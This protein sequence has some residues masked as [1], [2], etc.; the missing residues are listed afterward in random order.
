MAEMK[1]LSN[2]RRVELL[3]YLSQLCEIPFVKRNKGIELLSHVLQNI[4]SDPTNAEYQNLNYVKVKERLVECEACFYLLLYVGFKRCTIANSERLK[5]T[6]NTHNWNAL[7]IVNNRIQTIIAADDDDFVP[8][9]PYPNCNANNSKYLM[10]PSRY[11]NVV[12]E[13][14]LSNCLCFKVIT[15]V[16]RARENERDFQH[17][18]ESIGNNYNNIELMN[19]FNHLLSHH[20]NELEMEEIYN[21]LVKQIYNN[22]SCGLAKC[23]FMRRNHRNRTLITK[24]EQILNELYHSC[25]DIVSQQLLDRIHC[26]FLHSYDIG[27]KLT[28]QQKIDITNEEIKVNNEND[29]CFDTT[30]LQMNEIRKLTQSK[31]KNI[32]CFDRL[33]NAPNKFKTEFTEQKQNVSEQYQYGFRFYYWKHSKSDHRQWIEDVSARKSFKQY[34]NLYIDQKYRNLEDE[35]TNNSVCV[36]SKLQFGQLLQKAQV[37]VDSDLI[38]EIFCPRKQSA[39]CY[40][41][42]YEQTMSVEHIISLMVY[43]NYD[44]LQR[45]FSET[46]RKLQNETNESLKNRHRNYYFFAKLL[47]ECVGCFG[48]YREQGIGNHI[49]V[50]HGIDKVL[51]FTTMDTYVAGPFSTTTDYSVATNFCAGKGMILEMFIP[52]MEWMMSAVE[53]K[54]ALHRI[55]CMDMQWFSDFV[56]E[57]EI[58]CIGGLNKIY[59]KSIILMNGINYMSYIGGLRRMI[60][61]MIATDNGK[62]VNDAMATFVASSVHTQ[63]AFRLL[64]HEIYRYTPNDTHAYEFKGCPAYIEQILHSHC[65]NVTDITVG[66]GD[67]FIDYVFMNKRN[68]WINLALITTVFPKLKTIRY[69]A[70]EKSVDWLTQSSIYES[71]LTF[72]KNNKNSELVIQIIYYADYHNQ[73]MKSTSIQTYGVRFLQYSW[74]IIGQSNPSED[75]RLRRIKESSGLGKDVEALKKGLQSPKLQQWM[76]CNNLTETFMQKLFANNGKSITSSVL[77]CKGAVV[78]I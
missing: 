9:L 22:K 59:Y 64:S 61:N 26:Y 25:E 67:P 50:F 40:D 14:N 21:K 70:F 48:M 74:L 68:K 7:N 43:C 63:M 77:M 39:K 28:N 34:Q 36:I 52:T 10:H 27:Y 31:Y 47:R 46:F 62:D 49:S 37:Y 60:R 17:I 65:T 15:E 55:Q 66:C 38:K 8:L 69:R 71:V 16:L 78:T 51:T 35:L 13:C 4:S 19:D 2:E 11:S 44:E 42:Y 57:Q 41:M 18:F 53:G 45:K 24:N 75:E 5:W 73:V 29:T 32:Q 12:Y 23:S 6:K 56:N 3:A 76:K 20:S 30:V 72:I 1:A 33:H 58:F 54:D